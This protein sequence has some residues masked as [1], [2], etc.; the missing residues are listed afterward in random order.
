MDDGTIRFTA[1]FMA[2]FAM[3][4]PIARY[5]RCSGSDYRLF[6]SPVEFPWARLATRSFKRMSPASRC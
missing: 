2:F 1:V 4:N 6:E 5:S 3:M